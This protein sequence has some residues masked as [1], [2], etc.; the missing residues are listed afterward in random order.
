VPKPY[1]RWEPAVNRQLHVPAGDGPLVVASASADWEH[2]IAQ[3]AV[4]QSFP[5]DV[6]GYSNAISVAAG[7]P[8]QDGLKVEGYQYM[9]DNLAFTGI[10]P[11]NGEPR[12]P[13]LSD[14]YGG[15]QYRYS[16]I[17]YRIPLRGLVAS[18]FQG[19]QG[20]EFQ[21]DWGDAVA[22]SVSDMRGAWAGAGL[23][24]LD[25][26][27]LEVMHLLFVGHGKRLGDANWE[28]QAAHIDRPM[29]G[30]SITAG[31]NTWNG[32]S[33][34]KVRMITSGGSPSWSLVLQY[35][36]GGAWVNAVSV[37]ADL[38]SHSA[39]NEEFCGMVASL[40]AGATKLRPAS[41]PSP[42]ATQETRFPQ[43]SVSQFEPLVVDTSVMTLRDYMDELRWIGATRVP[44]P[45]LLRA[46]TDMAHQP[47]GSSKAPAELRVF[48]E[49]VG[50]SVRFGADTHLYATGNADQRGMVLS[51]AAETE[52]ILPMDEDAFGSA[53]PFAYVGRY[54]FRNMTSWVEQR[55][56]FAAGETVSGTPT[57][58]SNG[59]GLLW[60]PNNGGELVARY[61]DNVGG[62]WD[63]SVVAPFRPEEWDE[64]QAD[65]AI[66]WTGA[67]GLQVGRHD[68]E[69]RIVVNGQTLATGLTPTLRARGM[70]IAY[71]GTQNPGVT[72]K[73]F[74]GM[75]AG[76][77]L[78]MQAVTD[79]DLYNAFEDVTTSFQNPSFEIAGTGPG[80]AEGWTWQALQQ[81]GAWAEFNAYAEALRAWRDT[82][83]QFAAG[84][85]PPYEW[86]YDDETAR[87]AA[88]GFTAE[89]V[90][91][92]AWQDDNRTL[93][94]L[95]AIGPATWQQVDTGTNEGWVS[96]LTASMLAAALFNGGVS[97]SEAHIEQFA[98]WT[99][100]LLPY[101][102]APWYAAWTLVAPWEDT[103][104]P[105]SGPTGWTGWFD[106]LYGGHE[107]PLRD[108]QFAEAWGT[109]PF[110]TAPLG[111]AWAPGTAL[112]GVLVGA[113]LDFPF[114]LDA[115]RT[116]LVVVTDTLQVFTLELGAGEYRDMT[117]LETELAV[118]WNAAGGTA[119]GLKFDSTEVDGKPALTFGW[120][121]T[122]VAAV[123]CMFGVPDG[124]DFNDARS[125]IGL[126]GFGPRGTRSDV[127]VPRDLFP[128][129]P[130]Y[131]ADGERMLLDAWSLIDLSVGE[132][133]PHN[134]RIP[135]AY[136][137]TPAIFD[138]T[139]S[140]GRWLDEFE[141]DAWF[142]AGAAW[143]D[144]YDPG[145]LTAAV[146]TGSVTQERFVDT[147]WPDE[148]WT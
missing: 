46:P 29:G 123:G 106:A 63:D 102:G 1:I 49:N 132:V 44:A 17:G 85:P 98:R 116:R 61:Y 136:G 50:W 31:I 103:L 140:T 95:T 48:D 94:V 36:D 45:E 52:P 101:T 97:S 11:V 20:V 69:L 135:L 55:V 56:L 62:A 70:R 122:T 143:K 115:S 99:F 84:F 131:F 104:G 34:G 126:D 111:E 53:V 59:I 144:E 93:W 138:T 120:D 129:P 67:R 39:G 91:K 75:W 21:A 81:E 105:G 33:G 83:E 108:E 121:G 66:A 125:T 68:G 100:P 43:I 109:D 47:M 86:R 87:L 35:W 148:L 117:V 145:D 89:D 78:Y 113:P 42:P 107:H 38:L 119:L 130:G 7:T 27:A 4:P 22:R 65:I 15:A 28:Y 137:F 30:Y 24:L 96:A 41:I 18:Q 2:L 74:E 142:G 134:Y 124:D 147:E 40:F 110:S 57:P 9:P 73:S 19:A 54:R 76:G 77:A 26:A 80:Q 51:P 112:N 139:V 133:L 37:S 90:G 12:P 25:G 10:D 127:S 8:P 23:G 71:I 58:T 13:D 82:I 128:N 5:D 146:F 6:V 118:L 88:T 14:L 79:A 114:D 32:V 60:Q 3:A 72:Y 92:L 141:L 16:N 64:V